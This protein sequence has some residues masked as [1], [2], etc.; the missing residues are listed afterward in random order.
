MLFHKLL[1]NNIKYRVTGNIVLPLLSPREKNAR[2]G[3][4]NLQ[5]SEQGAFSME[6]ENFHYLTALFHWVVLWHCH[7]LQLHHGDL[8]WRNLWPLS[9]ICPFHA[10]LWLSVNCSLTVW[11][12]DLN[13]FSFF[14]FFLPSFKNCW[15][16]FVFILIVILVMWGSSLAE[17]CTEKTN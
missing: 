15:L 8:P 12:H 7:K 16:L 1:H 9:K 17:R 4:E 14:S 11:S 6:V 2:K 5:K 10:D 13:P 3:K